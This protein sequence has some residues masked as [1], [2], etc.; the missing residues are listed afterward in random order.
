VID[1]TAM[2][3]QPAAGRRFGVGS[4]L[5]LLGVFGLVALLAYGLFR[6]NLSQ[7]QSGPAP[8]FTLKLYPGYDGGYGES[9]D[10]QALRGKIV[11]VNFW[12]SWC[13]PCR[14][15]AQLLEDT[16]R[17]Y[18]DQGVVLIGVGYN[19]TEPEALKYMQ[20]FNLTYPNGPDLK[21]VIARAYHTTGVP[22]TYFLD[23]SGEIVYVEIGPLTPAKMTKALA[24]L[25]NN[26]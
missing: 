5:V 7:P 14:D 15:E 4:V 19:D 18:K 6:A 22:E 16:W 3:T 1:Q 2:D 12:A 10:L 11:I 13:V 20:E 24:P 17:Q 21:G 25:L 9:I 8:V 23:R 26:K